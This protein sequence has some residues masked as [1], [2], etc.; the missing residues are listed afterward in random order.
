MAHRIARFAGAAALALGLAAGVLALSAGGD[1]D[2][3]PAAAS[4]AG[5]PA[6]SDFSIRTEGDGCVFDQGRGGLVYRGLTIASKSSGVL[7]LSFYAQRDSL[8]DILPGHV[9]T[10][11]TFDED[12]HSHTFD[13]VVPATQDDYDSGY[14]ECYW[15]TTGGD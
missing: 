5:L 1:D 6:V 2:L 11:L 8:D 3:D 15:T 4:V 10:A 13:L 9:S 7:E 14:D 12:T